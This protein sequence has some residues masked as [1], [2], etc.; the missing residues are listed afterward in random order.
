MTRRGLVPLLAV[1][2]LALS[3]CNLDVRVQVEV[4]DDGS[5]SV[6]VLATVDPAALARIGGDLG[7]VLSLE[8]LRADGWTVEGPTALADGSSTVRLSQR[9]DNAQGAATV[10]EDLTGVGGPF[11][12]FAV[13]RSQS[14][15]RTRWGF[16]GTVDLGG[17]AA[18]PDVAPPVDG[19]A[20]AATFEEL[21]QQLGDSLERLI[22]VR[23]GVR[24]PG[25]V[26]SNATTK[27]ENGAVWQVGFGGEPLEL[28]ATGRS[29]RT[30]VVALAVVLALAVLVGLIVLLVRLAGRVTT[31]ERD[32]VGR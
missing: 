30:G 13:T 24:L 14:L 22:R 29:T 2:A 23:V 27:A 17:D 16:R 26:R 11:Q 7:A 18:V 21:E 1:V 6:E 32:A 20:P 12:G 31:P 3:A 28:E 15:F 9:F 4:A 8:E 19:E 25:D 10:F 5:G